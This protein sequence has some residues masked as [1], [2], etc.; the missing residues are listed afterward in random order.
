M[1]NRAPARANEDRAYRALRDWLLPGTCELCPRMHAAA[2]HLGEPLHLECG[3]RATELHH[4]RKRS[5]AGA[6]AH[7]DNVVPCCHDGNMAVEDHPTIALH[8]G[9]VIREGHPD[10]DRLSARA[11][12]KAQHG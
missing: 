9:L 5:S 10:W 4:R 1:R 2:R 7:P 6:L 8:A 3:Q 11:W 12:R